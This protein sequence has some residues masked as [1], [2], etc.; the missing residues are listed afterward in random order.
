MKR[1]SNETFLAFKRGAD[2]DD[3]VLEVA[4]DPDIAGEID[5]RN[6]WRDETDAD[7]DQEV[8]DELRHI[9]AKGLT[10]FWAFMIKGPITKRGALKSVAQRLIAVTHLINPELLSASGSG[11][12]GRFRPGPPL[13][14]RELAELAGCRT[15]DLRKFQRQFLAAWGFRVRVQPIRRK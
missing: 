10:E 12:K 5:Q 8:Q 9:G 1:A 4:I 7:H 2:R 11:T 15:R 3:V 14:L 6:G 13:R